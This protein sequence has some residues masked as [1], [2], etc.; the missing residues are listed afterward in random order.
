MWKNDILMKFCKKSDFIEKNMKKLN[1]LKKI[2]AENAC[3]FAQGGVYTHLSKKTRN[4]RK[5]SIFSNNFRPFTRVLEESRVPSP[6]PRR[7]SSKKRS[8]KCILIAQFIVNAYYCKNRLE[9]FQKRWAKMKR[10][11]DGF[12]TI[13]TTAPKALKQ[14]KNPKNHRKTIKPKTVLSSRYGR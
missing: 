8:S 5:L 14:T 2:P 13:I 6:A 1:L 3:A 7:I 4:Y 11:N 12:L 9:I 10:L